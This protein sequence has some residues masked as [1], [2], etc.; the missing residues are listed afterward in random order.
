MQGGGAE[1]TISLLSSYL[2]NMEN[3]VYIVTMDDQKSFYPLP[4][5]IKHVKLG[6]NHN[7]QNIFRAMFNNF[8]SLLV[9]HDCFSDIRPDVVISF[10]PNTIFLSWL[11]KWGV[12]YKV[13]GSERTNPFYNQSGFWNR[14]KKYIAM[15]C[16]GYV[17]QTNG[18]KKYYSGQIQSVGIVLQN[19]ILSE[20]FSKNDLAWDDRSNV[21]A[22]GRMDEGKCFEDILQAFAIVHKQFPNVKLDLY[23]DGPDKQK[24]MIKA[25]ELG[26]LDVVR[27][28]GRC[29]TIFEEYSKHK[30]FIMASRAEGF[31]N[32]LLEAMASGCACV[33]AD[34]DF[35]PSELITNGQNGFLFSVHDWETLAS[36]V[37]FLLEKDELCQ[38]LAQNAKSV[39][40]TNNIEIIGA[41]FWDY[42]KQQ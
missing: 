17:F 21:C 20:K 22:V 23:G 19:G 9:I 28:H 2:I 36:Y 32:V 35:G 3:E 42:L 10:Q 1:R 25:T 15:L 40:Q 6:V 30:I 37:C 11:A 29:Q 16:D 14:A 12:G 41:A 7:S 33:V 38:Q 27:F 18:V 31:P 5:Q 24:L 8:H 4:N 26:F 13:I 39:R 34:C